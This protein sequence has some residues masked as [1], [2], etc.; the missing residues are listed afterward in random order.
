MGKSDR[1]HFGSVSVP[2]VAGRG[3]SGVARVLTSTPFRPPVRL[4]PAA[5]GPPALHPPP[6]AGRPAVRVGAK[7]GRQGVAEGGGGSL[8]GVAGWG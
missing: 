7:S 5:G 2:G 6:A 4:P 3:Y 1:T 8:H